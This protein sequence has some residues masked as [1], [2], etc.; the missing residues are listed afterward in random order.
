MSIVVGVKQKQEYEGHTRRGFV[1]DRPFVCPIVS[2]LRTQ[3]EG[4]VQSDMPYLLQG[5]R[6][7][8]W[9]AVLLIVGSRRIL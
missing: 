6:D 8:N 9:R 7:G 5:H 4:E 1:V 2:W 3:S